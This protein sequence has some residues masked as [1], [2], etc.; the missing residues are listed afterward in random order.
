MFDY[1]LNTPLTFIDTQYKYKNVSL[2]FALKTSAKLLS[3]ISWGSLFHDE[4]F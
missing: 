4:L 1:V 3:L 2:C